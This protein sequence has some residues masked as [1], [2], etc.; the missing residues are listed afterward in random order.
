MEDEDRP[1]QDAILEVLATFS[2]KLDT[3]AEASATVA[4]GHRDLLAHVAASEAR[5]AQ[6]SADLNQRVDEL[7]REVRSIGV[8]LPGIGNDITL[9]LTDHIDSALAAMLRLV[10]IRLAMLRRAFEEAD[11]PA[12]TNIEAGAVMG[13]TQAA[14][15]RLEQRIE[16]EF[17]DLGRQLQSMAT[18]IDAVV[19]STEDLANRPVVSGEQLRKAASAVKE[20][21]VA[22]NR[23]RRD[24]RGGPRKLG[25]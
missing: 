3:L 9:R 15:N 14:W 24:R 20:T 11:A 25:G 16:T 6:D 22:A 21:V 10:D 12:S 5:R 4:E 2:H 19:T 13:A 7:T 8:G 17:D 1:T 18:L 23:N